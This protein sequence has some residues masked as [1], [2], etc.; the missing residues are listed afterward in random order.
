[1]LLLLL[2]K[3]HVGIHD[4]KTFRKVHIGIYN[5]FVR[6]IDM[7]LSDACEK[8]FSDTSRV[9]NIKKRLEVRGCIQMTHHVICIYLIG[10]PHFYFS[11]EFI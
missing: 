6:R 7:E 10:H 1:M 9:G 8:K 2:L 5:F 11:N 3:N 4:V